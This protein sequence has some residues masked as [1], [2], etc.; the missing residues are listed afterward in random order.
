MSCVRVHL[1]ARR[2]EV[3]AGPVL[4]PRRALA[5]ACRPQSSIHGR[6]VASAPTAAQRSARRAIPPLCAH[7]GRV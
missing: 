4:E 6:A 1:D 2:A 3:Y 5:A 7:I